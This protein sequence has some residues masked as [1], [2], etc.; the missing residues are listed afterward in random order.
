[1]TGD[2]AGT[3]DQAVWEELRRLVYGSGTAHGRTPDGKSRWA[4][5][6]DYLKRHA[7]RHAML[8]G[9]LT[10][11]LGDPEFLVH[12]DAG[13]L[14]GVL[15]QMTE[16]SDEQ[17]PEL[18][19]RACFPAHRGAEPEV[20]RQILLIDAARHGQRDLADRL[21]HDG[22]RAVRWATG[23]GR[24]A[25]LRHCLMP[26]EN[27]GGPVTI[28]AAGTVNGRTVVVTTYS[29]PGHGPEAVLW[30]LTSG[31]ILTEVGRTTRQETPAPGSAR[32]E[33]TCA[34]IT[35]VADGTLLIMGYD[36]GTV[37]AWDAATGRSR[38]GYTFRAHPAGAGR[39]AGVTALTVLSGARGPLL[40][41]GGRDGAVR[42]W[43][44]GDPSTTG[45]MSSYEEAHIGGVSV[46][47]AAPDGGSPWHI[48]SAGVD[49]TVRTWSL[50]PD[51]GISPLQKIRGVP[52]VT[53]LGIS[54]TPE[55]HEPL[56][57]AGGEDGSVT[58]VDL[59]QGRIHS[60]IM[61]DGHGAVD[62][63]SW[64]GQPHAVTGNRDGMVTVWD[65]RTGEAVCRLA[66]HGE[67][68][69]TVVAVDL[70]G[71]PHMVSG[72]SDGAV[73]VW[74]PSAS[75]AGADD[76]GGLGRIQAT[77]ISPDGRLV[78]AAD[79]RGT[80]VVRHMTDG[81]PSETPVSIP[82]AG[83]GCP[84][85]L[86]WTAGE[87]PLLATADHR[88]LAVHG[89]FTADRI[90]P[91]QRFP[92]DGLNAI[93]VN[94][95][96]GHRLLAASRA[97]EPLQIWSAGDRRQSWTA[98]G[99]LIGPGDQ[100]CALALAPSHRRLVAG[101]TL[102]GQLLLWD[103]SR[104]WAVRFRG[105]LTGIISLGFGQVPYHNG[106][107]DVAWC[108]AAGLDS[109]DVVLWFLDDQRLDD[110]FLYGSGSGQTGD[111]PDTPHV[112]VIRCP[113]PV[114]ALA[115]APDG[116]IV[117]AQGPDLVILERR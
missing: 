110:S 107:S 13:A 19:Y 66:G 68:L 39:V 44:A 105:E 1:M 24:S 36:D 30:D 78:A 79:P 67:G 106:G 71:R 56:C 64:R 27:E 9:D 114:H 3:P 115:V 90:G 23:V 65:L 25:R 87:G 34:A 18:V 58:V 73:R 117:V 2:P 45:M 4:G 12:A 59:G 16:A 41:T 82:T 38:D 43:E 84:P 111:I 10:G 72:S 32:S 52:G 91:E 96:A 29:G 15:A 55:M 57:L 70:G 61:T 86:G 53:A 81:T 49:G 116:S 101:A 6:P 21:H 89:P 50:S 103:Y 95:T 8:A 63:V 28:R 88:T 85:A 54:R 62:V 46:L 104:E 99:D 26:Q 40:V 7:A 37:H 93:A 97:A 5:A 42:I 112:E 47:S 76:P 109:G 69:T 51:D 35:T 77:V 14:G 74:D 20:R 22:T 33:P 17:S 100:L 113:D 48:V 108:L 92:M 11:L 31:R 102:G 98:P 60:A 80:V 83:D 75:S 94:D